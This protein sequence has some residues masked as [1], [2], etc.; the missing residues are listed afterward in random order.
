MSDLQHATQDHS[1]CIF[2]WID[3]VG[4]RNSD[5][6]KNSD[7]FD[8]DVLTIDGMNMPRW[9]IDQSNVR[10]LNIFREQEL[11]QIR[12]SHFK[13]LLFEFIPPILSLSIDR[14]VVTGNNHVR[15][16]CTG[17]KTVESPGPSS[18]SSFSVRW[19]WSDHWPFRFILQMFVKTG[20]SHLNFHKIVMDR[21]EPDA[22][23]I[24]SFLMHLDMCMS[25]CNMDKCTSEDRINLY[26][27]R[28]DLVKSVQ[29]VK[30]LQL[31]MFDQDPTR[32]KPETDT[33]TKPSLPTPKT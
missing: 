26:A 20:V 8:D 3:S 27:S 11:D 22:L 1:S 19:Q 10:D 33:R 28:F 16:V 12:P 17:D 30:Y 5:R 6:S 25:L 24:H 23:C 4:V 13:L 31:W 21:T 2:T 18:I 7:G 29:L 32:S 9:R 15:Q 14:P